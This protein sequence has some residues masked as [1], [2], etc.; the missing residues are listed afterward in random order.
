[1]SVVKLL[2][3]DP[4]YDFTNPNGALYV[5]GADEDSIRLADMIRRC[6][7]RLSDITVTL[8]S[9]RSV[10]IAHPIWW[11]D[12]FGKHPDPFTLIELA[13]VEGNYPKWKAFSPS[14]QDWSVKYINDLESRGRYKHCIWPPHCLIGSTGYSVQNNIFS[15]LMEWEA[16]FKA[17]NWVTKGSCIFTEHFSALMAE[18]PFSKDPTTMLNKRFIESFQDADLIGITGQALSHC[19]KYTVEDFADNFGENNI[20]KFCFIENTCSSV[21]GFEKQ[22]E[23]FISGMK[24]RGMQVCNSDEFLI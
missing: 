24:T 1:M 21:T 4:Q 3:I 23:D 10:H 7:K 13:D 15:S 14:L 22:G 16:D 8:D 20:K 5:S 6:G 9:H 18:V 12:S 11:V 19:V 2:I 17:V